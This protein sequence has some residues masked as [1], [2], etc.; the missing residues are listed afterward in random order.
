MAFG[1]MVSPSCDGKHAQFR[2]HSDS[3]VVQSAV[4][5]SQMAEVGWTEGL[6]G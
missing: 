4:P 1:L 6:P 5:S 3:S 2:N